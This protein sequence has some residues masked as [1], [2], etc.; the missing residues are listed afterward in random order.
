MTGLIA[1]IGGTNARFALVENGHLVGEPRVMKCADYAGPTQA[2]ETFLSAQ[3]GLPVDCAAFAVASPIVGD[4]VGLT[5]SGWH[6]SIEAARQQLKLRRLEVIND[7]TAVALSIP[8]LAPEHLVKLGGE[9]PVPQAPIA[10][11]GPGTGLGVSALLP[12]PGGGWSAL[13]TEGGH[14]TMAA[15]NEREDRVLTWLRRCLGGHVSAER[16]VSGTGLVNLYDALA[17]L[18]GQAP[19]H[20]TPDAIS[21]HGLTGSCFLAQEALS[22]FFSML[23]TVAGNLA[24]SLGARGGVYIAGGILPR[25]PEALVAS[26][27]RKRFEDKGRFYN[28]LT[29]IPSWLVIHPQPAFAG[30]TELV[31]R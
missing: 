7:F 8:H 18:E 11:L 3:A 10:V 22:M 29:P 27:F 25:M 13:A 23:G 28:Y 2:A 15:A 24:L 5:N 26:G 9:E 20:R 1:D 31:S 12:A 17:N 6:F 14:V 16:V 4:E 30:L 21:Y 19:V